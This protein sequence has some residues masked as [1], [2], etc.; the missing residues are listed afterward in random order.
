MKKYLWVMAL[1][2]SSLVAG[3]VAADSSRAQQDQAFLNELARP[4]TAPVSPVEV[5]TPLLP[6]LGVIRCQDTYCQVD[7]NCNVS[8]Y[9]SG[10]CNRGTNRCVPY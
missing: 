6:A 10:F 8:C 9:N 2:L 3:T 4:A 7:A 1:V 5:K